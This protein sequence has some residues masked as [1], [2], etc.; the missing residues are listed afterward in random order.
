MA[1]TVAIPARRP[2]VAAR[3]RLRVV[4][5]PRRSRRFVALLVAVAAVGVFG[6]VS[7]NALAAEHAFRARALQAD[8]EAL[9]VTYDE[10][11][12]Q[13]ATL[14]SPERVRRVATE[15]LQMVP[16]EQPAYLVLERTDAGAAAAPRRFVDEVKPTLRETR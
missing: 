3:P 10:L 2:G 1:A 8:V 14:A 12:A 15:Q 4:G 16:A 6:V 7:L 11:T 5:P 9:A 13:V